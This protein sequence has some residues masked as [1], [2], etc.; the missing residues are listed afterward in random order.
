MSPLI[1]QGLLIAMSLVGQVAADGPAAPTDQT[2]RRDEQRLKAILAAADTYKIYAGPE[3]KQELVR[4]PQPVLRFDDTVTLSLQGLVYVWTDDRECPLAIASLFIRADGARVDEFQSLATAGDLAA[5]FD[6][7]IVWQPK[8]PGLEIQPLP[9]D[10]KVPKS[11][12]L[13]LSA[14]RNIAR[15][16]SASVTDR[17]TGRQE[18]RLLAQP[19]HR[20]QDTDAGLVDGALFG[21]AK[22]T[23]PE[24]LLVVEA[25]SVDGRAAWYYALT[26]MTERECFARHNDED[27]WTLAPNPSP[28]TPDEPYFNRVTR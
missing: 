15:R 14:M 6:S 24:V 12:E 9:G 13:R 10:D 5:E 28:Q 21:F 4:L 8:L 27:I 26:R 23:N 22:G 19:L 3:R 7:A 16:F 25:R 17:A 20:Y 1:S 2:R 18:L 11:K